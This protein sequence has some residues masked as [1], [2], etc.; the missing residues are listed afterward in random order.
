MRM[1]ERFWKQDCLANL[2]SLK[3]GCLRM[4]RPGIP[5][6]GLDHQIQAE[7]RLAG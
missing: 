4:R 1:I 2:G 5:G 3:G 7:Q 6:F